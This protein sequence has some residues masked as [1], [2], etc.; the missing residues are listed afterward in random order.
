VPFVANRGPTGNGFRY[1]DHA[2]QP[3]DDRPTSATFDRVFGKNMNMIRAILCTTALLASA[4]CAHARSPDDSRHGASIT[5]DDKDGPER[6]VPRQRPA[7]GKPRLLS[8][9]Q[10]SEMMLKDETVYLQLT[11]YGMKQVMEPQDAHDKDEGFLGSVLK[12]MALSG[13]KQVLDH[14]LALSLVDTRSA[15]VR[16]GEVVFVTCKG[17]EVFN[18]VKIN[19]QVQKY[20]Q[21]SAEDFVNNVNRLRATLPACRP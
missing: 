1:R 16:D 4:T 6:V 8:T 2:D 14:G 11:D 5:I 3:R 9:N 19:D 15:L 21:A 7:S 18:Q 17:K 20:P 13:V 12:T 10:W